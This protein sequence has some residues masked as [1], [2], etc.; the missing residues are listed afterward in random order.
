MEKQDIAGRHVT[1]PNPTR[2]IRVRDSG[3][4]LDSGFGIRG[5]IEA[6]DSGFGIQK[7]LSLVF[8]FSSKIN[9]IYLE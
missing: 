1:S 8:F 5:P 3:F 6:R 9:R 2:K 4:D 7:I